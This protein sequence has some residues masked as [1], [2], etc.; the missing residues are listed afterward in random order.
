M[1]KILLAALAL[2][3][4]LTPAAHAASPIGMTNGFYVDPDSN[5]AVW[6]RGHANDGRAA[7]I[8]SSIASRPIARWFGAWSGDIKSAVSRYVGA[9][10]TKLPV[11]VAYNIPG[12]DAC[13]GHS[14]GGAGSPEAYRA[15]I[16]AF[17]AGI[18]TRPAV[19]IIEPDSLADFNCMDDAAKATRT[20]MIKY[21]SE[22]FKAKAPN[23]WAYLDA[24][25]AKWV[26]AAT[27]AQRLDAAGVR[28]VRGFSINVSNYYTTAESKSYGDTLNASLP[29]YTKP[30][31]IDTSRNGK[32]H[33]GEWCNPAGRKIGTP[34]Q[35][36]GGAEMLLW[37]KV[38]GDSD[39]KCGTAPN[40]PAGSFDAEL[41]YR[42]V[43]GY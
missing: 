16:S 12:R 26:P 33:N 27:M 6:V 25:N 22:Q 38:P 28:N 15:W 37:V 20:A 36:G 23:T 19:V 13:G 43:F 21:A 11:L 2:P 10:G 8:R 29:G 30:F 5:P 18:G 4:L 9:T 35:Q 3:F 40:T 1:K 32:G 7:A 17:A 14:G 39:G 41:A 34:A 31:V 42:L 24:G